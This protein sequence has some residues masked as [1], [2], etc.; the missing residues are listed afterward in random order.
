[1]P[2]I[3]LVHCRAS[4]NTNENVYKIGKTTDFNKRLSGYDKGTIPIFCIYVSECDEFEKILIKIFQTKFTLR[5][6]YGNE[7]FYGNI[8][9]MINTIIEEYNK[10]K[11]EYSVEQTTVSS[12]QTISNTNTNTNLLIKM[13]T[14]IKNKLNR[15]LINDMN[16]FLMN[17]T[18]NAQ[19]F[20]NSQYYC[21][22]QNNIQNYRMYKQQKDN[23]LKFGDY[24][25]MNYAFV[26]N[27]CN[28]VCNNNDIQGLKLIERLKNCA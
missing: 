14:Q 26:N 2:Y 12:L 4:V 21:M 3:Y 15:I 11:I 9:L 7:Y 1:M 5:Q 23:K 18:M 20:N 17:I 24:L 13:K 27:L 19:E 22:L 10:Q 6:D 8:S 25:D 16:N 28:S